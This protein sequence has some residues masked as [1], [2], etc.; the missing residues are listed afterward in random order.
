MAIIDEV[1]GSHTRRQPPV[2]IEELP[3]SP[4]E[5][6]PQPSTESATAPPPDSSFAAQLKAIASRLVPPDDPSGPAFQRTAAAALRELATAVTS[7]EWD[8]LS[9]EDQSAAF[10]PAIL[11]NFPSPLSPPSSPLNP[12]LSPPRLTPRP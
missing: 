5:A 6:Q 8:K 10:L 12:S 1:T 2:T 3:D 4:C 11:L 9:R 7:P